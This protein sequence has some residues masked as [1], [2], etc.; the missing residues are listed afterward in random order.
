MNHTKL[1]KKVLL[2]LATPVL[3][4][5]AVP[6]VKLAAQSQTETKIRLMAE[7]LRARDSGDLATAKS[8]FEQLLV[9]VPN[10]VTVQRLLADVNNRSAAPVAVEAAPAAVESAPA[11]APAAEVA[12]PAETAAPAALAAEAAAEVAAPVSDQATEIAKAEEARLK[13][14]IADAKQANKDAAKLAKDGDYAAAN[15]TLDAAIASLPVNTLTEPSIA[16]LQATKNDLLLRRSQQLL[17]QGDTKGAQQA[18]DAYI[19]ATSPESKAA[20]Q[21][22]ARIDKAELKPSLQPI[23]KVNPAFIEEQKALAAILAKGRSQYNA[24][25]LEGAR[26]T[27]R[28]AEVLSSDNPEAKAMLKRI[29]EDQSKIGVLNREKTRATMLQEVA[30]AWTRPGVFQE[31]EI[32]TGGSSEA[33]VSALAQKLNSIV[34]PVVQF[35]GMPLDQVISTLGVLSEEYDT[36]SSGQKGVNLV[37]GGQI[38]NTMPTVR[39]RLTGMTLKRILDIVCDG[40]NHEYVVESDIVMVRPTGGSPLVTESLTVTKNA[41]GRMTGNVG[42]T[43]SPAPAVSDPFADPAAAAPVATGGGGDQS[44]AIRRFL[45]GAGVDFEKISGASVFYDQAALIVTQTPR[46]IEKIRQL[47]GRY[48]EVVKQVEIEARFMDVAEGNLNEFGI[49]W[50]ATSNR[51]GGQLGLSSNGF[52]VIGAPSAT[53]TTRQLSTA[54]GSSSVLPG[55]IDVGTNAGY[56]GILNGATFGDFSVDAQ[57]RALAQKTGSELLSAPKAT[58][59]AG[60]Q[61]ELKVVQELSYPTSY[62]DAEITAPTFNAAGFIT[63][64]ASFEPSIPEEFETRDVGVTLRVKPEVE[65]DLYTIN[66]TLDPEVV[67][68]EGFVDYGSVASIGG[69]NYTLQSLQPIFSVRQVRT[70]V[71]VWDGATVVM[72]GLT[73]EEVKRVDDKIPVLGDIPFIGR[74]FKSKGE[75]SQKR[76]LLIF[77]TANLVSPGG[78]LRNQ[79]LKGVEPGAVFQNPSYVSPGGTESRLRG[80]Q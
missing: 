68:F 11:A 24:G 38:S 42:A 17:A 64:P 58:V 2:L 6:A 44:Q 52:G 16:S 73:R 30:N 60:V 36:A 34:L 28:R 40:A 22:A 55:A 5:V 12:A 66:L 25:D 3:F 49:Q 29:A 13:G 14:L 8:N 53:A 47:I 72:G 76:N 18:L 48:N 45:Q 43:T 23:E 41:I 51:F 21:Q 31:R 26:E 54:A 1:P 33:K 71:T 57:L 67:E 15:S 79:S 10:D 70:E 37:L 35:D 56:V 77:V 74:A 59:L 27:F 63:T 7:G 9:L 62:S 80:T 39:I 78:S 46:N 4:S 20:A 65:D 50:N 75:S 32:A 61:A 19:A 69:Q